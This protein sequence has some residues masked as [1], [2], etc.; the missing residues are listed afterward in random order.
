MLRTPA[1]KGGTR[2]QKSG[3][4]LASR[5]AVETFIEGGR[6]VGWREWLALPELGIE[7]IK[8]KVDTGARTSALHA[9]NVR[10]F[11]RNGEQWVSF[12]ARPG[13]PRDRNQVR[14]E[15]RARGIRKVRNSGGDVE[16]RY[17]IVTPLEMG[18]RRLDVE[19]T[20]TNRTEMGHEMLLGRS[21]LQKGR[22]LVD[23]A[24]SFLQVQPTLS[25]R[26]DVE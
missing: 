8:A 4:R 18:G 12:V 7:R 3:A 21:A 14:C 10:P 20:L 13:G 25:Y 23:P 26:R 15:A 19:I 5:N 17:V 24:K 9:V 22:F 11:D 16:Q 6:L 2:R 1:R